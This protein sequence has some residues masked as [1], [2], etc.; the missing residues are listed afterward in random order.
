MRGHADV[1][2]G[3]GSVLR[4]SSKRLRSD[5]EHSA[6][7]DADDSGPHQESALLSMTTS[8]RANQL[9]RRNAQ[10]GRSHHRYRHRPRDRGCILNRTPSLPFSTNQATALKPRVYPL[11]ADC[12]EAAIGLGERG[13]FHVRELKAPFA[14]RP[15]SFQGL[16]EKSGA[17]LLVCQNLADD[18]L[19]GSL[20]HD[21]QAVGRLPRFGGAFSTSLPSR[22]RK[23][24]VAAALR[25]ARNP[26]QSAGIVR[27]G[28]LR[29]V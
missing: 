5:V 15:K 21:L 19:H 1:V 13:N 18:Q 24:N 2:P 11:G 14:K 4:R 28:R 29:S 8:A 22:R 27:R 16:L 23:S 25:L 20:R 10:G 6:A 12:P 26:R 17:E 3:A 9:F 7:S